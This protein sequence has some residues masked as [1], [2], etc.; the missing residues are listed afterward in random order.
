MRIAVSVT[1]SSPIIKLL[2]LESPVSSSPYPNKM[3][4]VA[5]NC[6]GQSC[7]RVHHFQCQALLVDAHQFTKTSTNTGARRSEQQARPSDRPC[8]PDAWS[9]RNIRH[10]GCQLSPPRTTSTA[11]KHFMCEDEPC[12][13]EDHLFVCSQRNAS[14]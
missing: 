11:R 3:P 2:T 5:S 10:W 6:Q 4:S 12:L 1:A 14:L 9:A 8:R 7:G 13:P